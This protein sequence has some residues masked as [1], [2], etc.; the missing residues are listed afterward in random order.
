M[1][2]FSEKLNELAPNINCAY[3]SKMSGIERSFLYKIIYGKRK[4]PSEKEVLKIAQLLMLSPSD[5]ETLIEAYY[6]DKEGII[7]YKRRKLVKKLIENVQDYFPKQNINFDN[8]NNDNLNIKLSESNKTTFY[9]SGINNSLSITKQILE[10]ELNEEHL[11]IKMLLQPDYSEFIKLLNI[12]FQEKSDCEVNHIICFQKNTNFENEEPYNLQCLYLL[13]PMLINKYSYFPRYYHGMPNQDMSML[14][15]PYF[16]ITEQYLL[17]YSYN[18]SNL[19]LTSD[20]DIKIYYKKFYEEAYKKSNILVNIID[21]F[22]DYIEFLYNAETVPHEKE[23][24]LYIEPCAGHHLSKECNSEII[25]EEVNNRQ[26]IV[27]LL[28]ARADIWQSNNTKIIDYFYFDAFID[29]MQTGKALEAY[30]EMYN[31]LT[32]NHK[33]TMIN[34]VINDIN[35][36]RLD[37]IIIK[38][39]KFKL[40]EYIEVM[41]YENNVCSLVV[42]LPKNDVKLIVIKDP[43][44]MYA[45]FDFLDWLKNSNL[46]YTREESEVMLKKLG[47]ILPPPLSSLIVF[48]HKNKYF[49]YNQ[50][51]HFLINICVF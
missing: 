8:I 20:E 36:G 34:N 25:K 46:V 38:P 49:N 7:N 5:I 2:I 51:T 40:T 3:L 44:L 13:M 26:T 48:F 29:E 27:N 42:K 12:I 16:I 45:F 9:I 6:M 50:K 22:H 4:A 17:L 28:N 15:M 21:N 30:S 37:I 19:I 41:A 47:I 43:E 23:H 18:M 35:K 1:G 32:P 39:D 11:V 10:Q 24:Y 14:A 31:S 33:N